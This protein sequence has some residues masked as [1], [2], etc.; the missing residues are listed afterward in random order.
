MDVKNRLRRLEQTRP[1]AMDP[2]R[3]RERVM[4]RLDQI[5]ERLPDVHLTEDEIRQTI[6][7]G[8]KFLKNLRGR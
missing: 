4:D 8:R 2:T 3:A 7:D 1:P 6:E 5:R